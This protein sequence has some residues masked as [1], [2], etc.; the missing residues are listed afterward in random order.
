MD[1]DKEILEGFNAGY[2]IEKHRPELAKQLVKA[3]EGVELPFITG[4]V[5]GTQEYTRERTSKVISKLRENISLQKPD[6]FK[7]KD[8]DDKDKGFEI[9]I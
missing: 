2:L 8:R 3:V 7:D 1:E 4:F 6:P 9:D 5:A